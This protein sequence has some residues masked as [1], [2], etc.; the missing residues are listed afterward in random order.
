MNELIDNLFIT[1]E[2]VVIPE[3]AEEYTKISGDS[4]SPKNY[5]EI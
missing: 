5:D 4:D 3:Q 2:Q 1:P